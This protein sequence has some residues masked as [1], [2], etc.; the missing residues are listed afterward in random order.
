[1]AKIAG[2]DDLP[3]GVRQHLID[4]MRDRRISLSDLN[5]LRLWMETQPDVPAGEWYKDFGSFKLCGEDSYSK[6]FLLKGQVGRGVKL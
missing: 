4:R 3:A 2:W 6:T 5:A 1:M